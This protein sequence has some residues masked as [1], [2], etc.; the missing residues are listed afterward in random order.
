MVKRL[1]VCSA[2]DA[3]EQGLTGIVGRKRE[4]VTGEGIVWRK[5]VTGEGIVWH[6]VTG[7]G[8]VWHKVTGEGIRIIIRKLILYSVY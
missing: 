2:D 8:I 5:R 3:L 4:K 6:K 1:N 7:E